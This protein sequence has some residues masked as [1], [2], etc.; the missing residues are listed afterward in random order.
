KMT[1]EIE[2]NNEINL[3]ERRKEIASN[4]EEVKTKMS[5][6]RKRKVRLV[7]VSKYKPVSDIL[8]AYEAGQRHF[9]ENYI[10]ELVEKNIQWHFIGSLQ[11]N[12]CKALVAIPNLWAVETIDSSRKA[13]VLNKAC[14]SRGEPLNIFIQVNTSEESTKGGIDPKDCISTIEYIENNC[15][16]LKVIGLMTI[17]SF[18]N[19]ENYKNQDNPDFLKLNQ[20]YEEYKI[21]K[22]KELELSMGMSNDYEEALKLGSTNI[23]VGSKIFGES[24][25]NSDLNPFLNL[26]FLKITKKLFDSMPRRADCN[27]TIISLYN[28]KS[29]K[30]HNTTT[31]DNKSFL[32]N[33]NKQLLSNSSITKSVIEQYEDALEEDPTVYSYDEVYDVMKKAEKKRTDQI[34]GKELSENGEKK[35]KYVN[36]MLRA[37]MIRKRDYMTVQEHKLQKEREA[38][39]DEFDDKEEGK[40]ITDFYRRFLDQTSRAKAVA[41]E[42]IKSE[43]Q[44][45]YKRKFD[46]SSGGDN[47]YEDDEDDEDKSEN[48]SNLDDKLKTDKQLAE[49]AEAS[50]KS[51]I[52]NEDDQIIDKRELLSA[53][54]NITKK[55][56][57]DNRKTI[58]GSRKR[59]VDNKEFDEDDHNILSKRSSEE[60]ARRRSEKQSH[61]LEMQLKEIEA[62]KKEEE[63]RKQEELI[64]KFSK[65]ND[66]ATISDARARYLARKNQKS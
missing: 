18:E 57:K 21:L 9:G 27:P 12:K 59:K 6:Q 26:S 17:G 63:A 37:A 32:K 14:S 55:K 30:S 56:D 23:R 64:K 61:E 39:G 5:L 48:Q 49:E 35:A 62:K 16:K 1:S 31:V 60:E 38:E 10:Q 54:L 36:N 40:D 34:K 19:S 2:K 52:L 43:I 46:N 66:E 41:I 33:V 4:L 7:A 29:S 47:K 65:K 53:G 3:E 44:K 42:S 11:S 50:G 13:D 45:K 8:L 51:V 20:L 22:G 28:I 24:F 58:N 25:L 15:F